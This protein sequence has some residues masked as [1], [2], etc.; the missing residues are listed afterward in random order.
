[1][2]AFFNRI[3]IRAKLP[4]IMVAITVLAVVGIGS[5]TTFEARR[6]IEPRPRSGWAAWPTAASDAVR[7]WLDTIART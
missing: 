1:M 6:A 2:P 7:S 3:R 5:V 4:A